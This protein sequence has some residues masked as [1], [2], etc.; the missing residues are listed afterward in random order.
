MDCC[1]I[2]RE[3]DFLWIVFQFVFLFVIDLAPN[4]ENIYQ[5]M[6][7]T[8]INKRKKKAEFCNHVIDKGVNKEHNKSIRLHRQNKKEKSAAFASVYQE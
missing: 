5:M 3:P 7:N 6:M 2:N 1:Y 8:C 4:P